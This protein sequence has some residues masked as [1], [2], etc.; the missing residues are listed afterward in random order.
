[1]KWFLILFVLLLP[2]ESI[3]AE[4][5]PA[6]ALHGAPKYKTNFTHFD[7]A[8]PKAPKG[9]RI[10]LSALGGFDS[11]NPFI[12]KG[13]PASEISELVYQ[14]L[15]EASLDEAFSQYG[16]LAES[17]RIADNRRSI[18]FKLRPQAKWSDGAPVTAKDVKFSFET[19][20][21]KGA[22]GYRSY[23]AEVDKVTVDGPL[24]ATFHF[25]IADNPELPLII[26][27][28]P[29]IPEHVWKNRDFGKTTLDPKS[30]VG[31]GPY[32]IAQVKAGESVRFERIKDWWGKDLPVN[33]GQFNF[34]IVDVIYFRDA[35][36]AIEAL[37]ADAY[38]LRQE[39]IAKT[40]ATGYH[41]PA[42]AKKL[43]IMETIEHNL[44]AGMQGYIFNTRRP[45]FKDKRVREAI[46]LAFDFEWSNKRFA[47]GSYTR[48][49]SYFDNSEMAATG[50]PQGREKEI[51]LQYKDKLPA[52]IFTKEFVIP[53]TDG[54][55]DN[56]VYLRQA[57][58][59]LD[60]AGYKLDEKGRRID[61]NTG[62]QMTF[63]IIDVQ[64][65]FER[66]TLPFVANL[67]KIGI[68]AR[69]RVIDTAQYQ[70]RMNDLDFDM[71][72]GQ[73]PQSLSPGNEQR[74][75]WSSAMAA[76]PGTRNLAGVRDPVVDALVARIPIAQT[77]GEL[78]ASVKALDR[79]LLWGHY[80]VPQWHLGAWRLAYWDRFDRPRPGPPYGL[81]VLETWWHK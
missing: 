33:K 57:I 18:T 32:K 49:D 68:N 31:S 81:P 41:G 25:K 35:S 37:F 39:N 28:L 7:Y 71:T 54:K 17:A 79:V 76:T 23:Y 19:L 61:P 63:E 48:T 11:L 64:A 55:G 50:L 59:L 30:A 40:W 5:T 69:F 46:A 51:L 22:P 66:W 24:L 72:V 80:V 43:I 77:R 16:Q 10:R 26:G 20:M 73:F 65:A 34:D 38:D 44:P 62:K 12:L 29:I 6:L 53:K 45:I 74:N 27:Q 78:V 36:V 60:D 56:R 3:A 9:G 2:L 75:F 42:I 52:E 67:R 70:N 15:M 47:Y 1:M 21:T 4:L 14:T 8:N 58:K 13:L